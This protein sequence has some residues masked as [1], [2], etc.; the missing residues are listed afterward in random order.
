MAAFSVIGHIGH[1]SFFL[2]SGSRPPSRRRGAHAPCVTAP[3]RPGAD[4]CC[5][6]VFKVMGDTISPVR[7]TTRA[8][9]LPFPAGALPFPL[10]PRHPTERTLPAYCRPG[11]VFCGMYRPH[12]ATHRTTIGLAI[13][14][15]EKNNVYR[16]LEQLGQFLCVLDR[17]KILVFLHLRVSWTRN[18]K[19]TSNGFLGESSLLTSFG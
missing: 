13:V 18:T 1:S 10:T 12:R 5:H 6:S 17:N 14:W 9:A 3:F 2:Y 11:P 4:E 19:V 7:R 8:G 15:T 16:D